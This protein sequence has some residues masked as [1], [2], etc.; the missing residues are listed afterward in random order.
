MIRQPS[1]PKQFP[2][3]SWRQSGREVPAPTTLTA[4]ST[5]LVLLRLA[6]KSDALS[7]MRTDAVERMVLAIGFTHDEKLAGIVALATYLPVPAILLDESTQ[8]NHDT[9]IFAA[10]GTRDPMVSFEPGEAARDTLL[11]RGYRL[12][13]Q[14]RSHVG[15]NLWRRSRGHQWM[16][17]RTPAVKAVIN[18]FRI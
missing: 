4:M 17:G 7:P 14:A 6:K 12:S 3:R 16:S 2:G 11:Q 9:S 5:K 10:H 13:R 18:R 8:V 1:S 15:F